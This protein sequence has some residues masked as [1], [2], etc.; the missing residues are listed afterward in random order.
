MKRVFSGM[1][2]MILLLILISA[3]QAAELLDVKP[4]VAGNSVSVEVTADVSMTYTYYKVPGQA[5]AVVDIADADPEKVEPLIVVN[6]GSVS[7][8]SVDKAQIAGMVVSR[9]V[10]NLVAESDISVQASPDRKLLTVMFGGATASTTASAAPPAAPAAPAAPVKAEP[11]PVVQKA[12]A[13]TVPVAKKTE[14]EPVK[15]SALDASKEEDDPLGLDE[16]A[17]PTQKKA[18]PVA[19]ASGNS[20]PA[21]KATKLEPVVPIGSPTKASTVLKIVVGGSNI[22]ILTNGQVADF[23]VIKLS[24]PERLAIDI[25]GAK[26]AQAGKSVVINKFGVSKARVGVYPEYVRVVLD[27]SKSEF[28]KYTVTNI[29]DGLRISF[30]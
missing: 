3:A 16:P 17:T 13:E 5:R 12:V 9:L 26:N 22:D 15:P 30:K 24:S 10:F 20:Q 23:K 2:S 29:Q 21:A 19:V 14:A 8:I 18:A 27:S 28:P 1:L 6:K 4:I 11:E 25:S 7:S